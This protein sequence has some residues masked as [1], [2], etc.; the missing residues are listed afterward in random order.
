[1]ANK[2]MVREGLDLLEL[3]VWM[4]GFRYATCKKGREDQYRDRGRLNP[5]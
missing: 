2:A 1:M 3:L 5:R 4:V